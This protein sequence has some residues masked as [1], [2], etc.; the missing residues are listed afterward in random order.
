[1]TL[2]SILNTLHI[3][4]PTKIEKQRLEKKK[5]ALFNSSINRAFDET[6]RCLITP[7][8]TKVKRK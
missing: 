3:L 5:Q 4:F 1:M 6:L 8:D 2:K 7:I